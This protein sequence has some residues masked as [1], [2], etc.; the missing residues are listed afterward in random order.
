MLRLLQT[1]EAQIIIWLAVLAVLVAVA[2][3]VVRKFRDLAAGQQNQGSE[4]MSNFRELH[5]QGDLTDE[6]FRTIKNK[7][8]GRMQDELKRSE[9]KG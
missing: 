9:D 6:E 8:A 2:V 5:S 1:R 7:L 4:L 3:Y